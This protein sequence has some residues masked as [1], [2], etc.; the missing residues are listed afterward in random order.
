MKTFI[1]SS[2]QLVTLTAVLACGSVARADEIK[3]GL[4]SQFSGEY[5]W[6]GQE[7]RR[8]VAMALAEVGGKIDGHT[9]T[10]VERD[11]GGIN[12]QRIR[13]VSQELVQREQV[14]Y[15]AGG[16]FTPTVMAAGSVIN[17]AKIPYVVFN[18][19][20]ASVTRSSPYYVR[21]GVTQW[22]MNVPVSKWVYDQGGRKASIL[23]ADYATGA[24]AA[25]AFRTSF[26]GAGGTIVSEVKVPVGTVDF[27]SY[28]QRLK[29]DAPPYVFIFMPVGPM[30]VGLVKAIT[31]EK[32]D[33]MGIKPIYTTELQDNDLPAVGDGAIGSMSALHY[34]PYLDNPKNKAFV[35]AYHQKYGN[36]DIPGMST[37]AAYDG[38]QV[39]FQMIRAT[40]GKPDTDKAI[41]SVKG[42]KWDSPRGPVSIDNDREIVQN[43]YLRKVQKMP[44]GRLGNTV[45]A[46]F[47][48]IAEPWHKL[49]PNP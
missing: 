41:A 35:A 37:L 27:T 32:L 44:D 22:A 26:T 6:W 45:I 8:G 39:I 11:E 48:N 12:P 5:S 33:S 3:V 23:V 20:T 43:I 15:L 36:A 24:D 7:Y 38:M 1:R 2:L 18:S 14:Q 49:N 9:I 40:G 4:L 17:Q 47:P 10:I 34:G 30:S 16:A 13:Q 31:N 46:T 42:F 28:L 19:G 25:E 21:V 29:N